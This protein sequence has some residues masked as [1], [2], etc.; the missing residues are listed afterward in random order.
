MIHR[1]LL[2][3]N[4]YSL[5]S[6]ISSISFVFLFVKGRIPVLELIFSWKLKITRNVPVP[7]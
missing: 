5:I 7:T 3:I 2:R 1:W 4:N 6:I